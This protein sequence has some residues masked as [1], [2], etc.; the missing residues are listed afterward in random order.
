MRII[1][2]SQVG[3]HS[4]SHCHLP[5]DTRIVIVLKAPSDS[6]VGAIRVKLHNIDNIIS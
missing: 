4:I 2:V 6:V 5:T 1:V 3:G